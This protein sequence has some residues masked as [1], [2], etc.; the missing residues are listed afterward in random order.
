VNQVINPMIR[1]FNKVE[2]SV[3]VKSSVGEIGGFRG[4]RP[5]PGVAS[6]RDNMLAAVATGE[7]IMP[8][9]K[10]ART[11][12]CYKPMHFFFREPARV[13][14]GGLIDVGKDLVGAVTNPAKFIKGPIDGGVGTRPGGGTIREHGRGAGRKLLGWALMTWIGGLF[15]GRSG[16]RG[17]PATGRWAVG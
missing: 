1:G 12:R 3:R 5:I 13:R 7:F 9:D 2:S 6:S 4:R 11:C 16:R 10:T 8:A 14:V 15:A 17:S